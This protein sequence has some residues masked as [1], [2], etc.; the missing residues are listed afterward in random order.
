MTAGCLTLTGCK[1]SQNPDS[2]N[3]K[4]VEAAEKT[5]WND[6]DVAQYATFFHS[7]CRKAGYTAFWWD[8]NDLIDRKNL[9]CRQQIIDAIMANYPEEEFSY[10]KAT[11]G[12][13]EEDAVTAVH[14]M[15]TG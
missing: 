3:S 2:S 13:V 7:L 1:T 11:P 12:F 15:K 14:N 6:A 4:P 5:G 10:S 8:C 9:T